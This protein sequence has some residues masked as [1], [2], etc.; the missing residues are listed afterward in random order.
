MIICKN[1]H[2]LSILWDENL[3]KKWS[4]LNLFWIKKLFFFIKPAKD[5]KC[6]SVLDLTDIDDDVVEVIIV[7]FSVIKWTTKEKR[8][9]KVTWKFLF[10]LLISKSWKLANC[11]SPWPRHFSK[12]V[13]REIE[14]F[15]DS[16]GWWNFLSEV[17]SF[18]VLNKFRGK[19]CQIVKQLG[20][21]FKVSGFGCL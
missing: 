18:K 17:S 21:D 11:E 8:K 10:F 20:G 7:I 4:S 19:I 6:I 9:N 1:H 15:R 2:F 14:E 16:T 5:I 13:I 3:N 12:L